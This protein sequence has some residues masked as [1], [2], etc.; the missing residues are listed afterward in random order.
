MARVGEVGKDS[1]AGIWAQMQTHD[2]RDP[3][4]VK[5]GKMHSEIIRVFRDEEPQ[6][7]KEYPPGNLKFIREPASWNRRMQRQLGSFLY[8]SMNYKALGLNDLEHFVREKNEV[9]KID[10]GDVT[11]TKITAPHRIAREV[12]ERLDL[13]GLSA[14]HLYDDAEGAAID[15]IN[16]YIYSKNTA[17]ACGLVALA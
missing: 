13:M 4:P 7:S 2:F 15:V 1:G 10:N 5:R 17:V 3:D 12:M 16:E 14:T 6:F 11:L 8:D 9:P